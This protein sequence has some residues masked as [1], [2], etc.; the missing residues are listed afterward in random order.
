MPSPTQM[1]RKLPRLLKRRLLGRGDVRVGAMTASENQELPASQ[2]EI[3]RFLNK[4]TPVEASS[5]SAFHPAAPVRMRWVVTRE[6]D[7][8]LN[9]RLAVLGFTDPQLGAKPTSSSTV[10][11][12]GRQFFC[13][14]QD[15]TD[16]VRSRLM[17]KQLLHGSVGDQE[18]DRT[19]TGLGA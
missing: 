5:R 10:S 16:I 7:S 8:C 17:P 12:R 4:H 9:A 3:S 15:H 14:C 19:R 1:H 2:P 13:H 6:F 18:F 11:R